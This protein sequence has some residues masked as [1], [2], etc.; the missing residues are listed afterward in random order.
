MMRERYRLCDVVY[1]DAACIHRFRIC[2][3][4]A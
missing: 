2:E 1:L 3:A 4:Q